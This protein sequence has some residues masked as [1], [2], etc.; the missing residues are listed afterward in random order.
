MASGDVVFESEPFEVLENYRRYGP[1]DWDWTAK[2]K[3]FNSDYAG[4]AGEVDI[5]SNNAPGESSPDWTP[6]SR[7][8]KIT[9]TEV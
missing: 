6:G 9:I 7:K 2:F 8:F 1:G 3:N 5:R 4:A